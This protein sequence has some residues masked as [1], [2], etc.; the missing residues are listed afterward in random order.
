MQVSGG[1]KLWDLSLRPGKIHLLDC[2]KSAAVEELCC[3][4]KEL[5][6]EVSTLRIIREDEK[7]ID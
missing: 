3:Q 5:Q 2:R 6:V 7:E 4:V 1:R